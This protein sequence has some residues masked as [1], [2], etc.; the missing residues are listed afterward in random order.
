MKGTDPV[1]SSRTTAAG[2][3][4]VLP[5]SIPLKEKSHGLDF[6]ANIRQQLDDDNDAYAQKVI[7]H[8]TVGSTVYLLVQRTPKGVWEPDST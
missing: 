6:H 4:E 2:G 1:G 8:A 5:P 3:D 7:D